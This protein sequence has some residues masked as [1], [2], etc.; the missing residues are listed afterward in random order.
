LVCRL[1]DLVFAV[2]AS[3]PHAGG[4]LAEG[5]LDGAVLVCPWHAASFDIRTGLR[6]RGPECASLR[7]FDAEVI[8]DE[9]VVSPK[10]PA[11]SGE[12]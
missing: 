5:R 12:A 9:V 4:P 8:G 2:A 3:C 7:C 6:L 11:E 10:P 1:G